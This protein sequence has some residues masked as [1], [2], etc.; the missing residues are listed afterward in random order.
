MQD[1]HVLVHPNTGQ[2]FGSPVVPGTGWPGDPATRQTP[3]AADAAHVSALAAR[4]N[5]IPELDAVISVCRACPR[6]VSWREDVAVIKRRAF[7]DQPYWGR[8]VP[9]WGSERPRL[10]IVG[11]APAAHGANR[12]GR[13]FT[14]DRSGDQLYAAL[15]RAGLVNSPTS[16]D[17]ADGLR[18]NQIRISAPVRCAPPANAPTP[19]ERDA[20]WPWLR[21]EWRLVSE[22]VR[23]IVALGGVV[24]EGDA[25]GVLGAFRHGGD[26]G[27]EVGG[28]DAIAAALHPDGADEVL[29]E[30]FLDG[31]GWIEFLEI[32]G[33]DAF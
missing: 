24:D 33:G 5:S 13:M 4:A 1:V 15:H 31:A 8:P 22:H 14:G 9:G 12:T 21:A 19:A 25:E 10:L 28:L 27:I 23:A 30:V 16:V 32:L 7:A 17:A 11:L 29:D 20:C 2:A 6:L 26:A 3:V 18:A